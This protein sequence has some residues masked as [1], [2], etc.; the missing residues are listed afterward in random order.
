M[1][2]LH[3]SNVCRHA[4]RMISIIFGR[5]HRIVMVFRHERDNPVCSEN[6]REQKYMYIRLYYILFIMLLYL[7]FMYMNVVHLSLEKS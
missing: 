1:H 7:M 6:C 2:K 4:L 5:N 3:T